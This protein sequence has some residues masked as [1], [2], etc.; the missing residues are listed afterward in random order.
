[1]YLGANKTVAKLGMRQTNFTYITVKYSLE[2]TQNV[3][4]VLRSKIL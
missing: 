2:D 1:M 3:I 4:I